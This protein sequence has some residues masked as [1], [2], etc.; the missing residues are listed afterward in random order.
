ML[1]TVLSSEK[2]VPLLKDVQL[3]SQALHAIMTEKMSSPSLQIFKLLNQTNPDK[4]KLASLLATLSPSQTEELIHACSIFAQVLNLAEDMHHERRRR[5]HESSGS[6]PPTGSIEDALKKIELAQ[7][8][9]KTL[10]DTLNHT[11]IGA[12]LT[13]H[14]TEVQRQTI[15]DLLRK[16]HHLL[17]AYNLPNLS[18]E[19]QGNIEEALLSALLTL[20]QSD[21]TRHFKMT[22]FDEID[23]G[24][25][26]FPLSFFEALPKLYRN[27][28][29]KLKKIST[30]LTLP[31]I[32]HIGG[33][34]GGDRDGNP[35]VKADVL[36]HAFKQQAQT[37][38]HFYRKELKSLYKELS[39]SVRRVDVDEAVLALADQSPDKS[40]AREEEPYRKAIA[41]ILARTIATG[42]T[43][44]AQLSSHFGLGK[45]YANAAEFKADL[46]TLKNSLMNNG[47]TFLA[48]GR[49]TKLIRSVSLFE[50]YLMPLDLRQHA[51]K[52]AQTVAELFTHSGLED[53]LSL[54]EEEKQAVL[55]R[56]LKTT[57]PL[58]SPY[59]EYSEEVKTELDIFHTA[60]IIKQKYGQQ[61]IRQSII[62]N[63][64]YLSD[65][66]A[67]ALIL[68]ETGLL[69]TDPIA[70]QTSINIV[71]LFETIEAL[72]NAS[73][74]MEALFDLPWYRALL[75]SVQN[76]QEIMLGYSDS[77]K[78][79]GYVTSQ[80]S[81]YLAEEALVKTAQAH[82]VTLRLFHG[83]GG[84]VGRGGGPAYQAILAQPA[85]SV[86]GQI[87][88]TEQGEVITFKYADS[89][90]A[91]RNLETLVAATLEATLLPVQGQ[92]PDHNL[93]QSL[94]DHAFSTYRALITHPDFIDYFLQTSPIEQIAS[95]N[96]GSRPASRKSL[97]KIQDLRAIPWVFSWTQNRL[98]LPAWYGF[99]S[100]VEQL[101][102]EQPHIIQ[103]LQDIWSHSPFFQ[104]MLSNM[105]Q[106]L[107]KVDTQIA[108][109]YTVLSKN[110]ETAKEIFLRLEAEY[111]RSK[112]ALLDITQA[113]DLLQDNRTLARSLAL[114]LPYLNTLNWIQ[115]ELLKRLR[116]EPN[117]EHILS[118]IHATIN[119]IAQGLRNTG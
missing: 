51:Q 67:L 18:K 5:I 105:E 55:I 1:N 13:A 57:R 94:S 35:F 9:K 100:A 43:L 72:K 104:A 98:M 79:G 66:L 82:Q 20:W 36:N 12:I 28:S 69:K 11:H 114:R 63:C 26:Y 68:K 58:F 14:P 73:N 17:E 21:E 42:K 115:I 89:N 108:K 46:D 50:F 87:R 70:P 54:N 41:F 74:I 44:G 31:N 53:Y 48:M 95:L 52:H 61:A 6:T 90:N 84:S 86:N 37:L 7:I 2:D 107:A 33:W 101:K 27:L 62:S 110:P 19:D 116:T 83:R 32:I 111:E 85:H 56:E 106:V 99:G 38:F 40:I 34:I 65:I 118:Q 22:V 15:L 29:K 96:I 4:E 64:D 16:I 91:Q 23:N 93:L 49:L 109:A 102:K 71:P 39:V 3:L 92:E 47:S 25:A 10:Q 78:D 113:T 8:D 24:I 30:D 119:G 88:I 97:T 117:N 80:W 60:Y 103:Q 59:T 75:G 77:N 81:L 112:Q 76:V 45:P